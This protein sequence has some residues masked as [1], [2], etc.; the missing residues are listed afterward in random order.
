MALLKKA[1]LLRLP[2]IG[3]GLR[4]G[5]VREDAVDVFAGNLVGGHRLEIKG[6]DDGEDGRSGFGRERHVAQVNTI[7]GGFAHTED[8]RAALFEADVGG[9][10]DE[11]NRHA[12]GDAGQRSHTAW[13]NDHGVGGVRSA[14][15]VGS[16]I[17]IVL[18]L[19]LVAGATQEFRDD[20]VAAGD[21]ELFG[22]HAQAAVRED[23]VDGAHALV[24]LQGIQ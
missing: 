8:Q 13:E 9:A 1:T 4:Q 10:L 11:L 22:H 20:F 12:V 14:G 21:A 16:D 18:L 23:E 19:N 24:A 17:V 5:D 3:A 15:D 2:A 7:E 6:G